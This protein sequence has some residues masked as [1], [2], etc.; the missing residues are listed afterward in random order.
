MAGALTS[1]ALSLPRLLWEL[2]D[3]KSALLPA[4]SCVTCRSLDM[5]ACVLDTLLALGKRH[6]RLADGSLLFDALQAPLR[7][8]FCASARGRA[9]LGPFALV[10]VQA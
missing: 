10:R 3:T 6:A 9:V 4:C 5:T 8:F 2:R 7:A 1:F